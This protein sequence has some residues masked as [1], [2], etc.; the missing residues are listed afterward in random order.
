MKMKTTITKWRERESE[1][2]KENEKKMF[3][4]FF[5]L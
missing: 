2:W 1:R 3:E 4:M 5:S